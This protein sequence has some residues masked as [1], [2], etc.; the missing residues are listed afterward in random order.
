MIIGMEPPAS[1]PKL[2][3]NKSSDGSKGGREG[4]RPPP[5]S[6]FFQ[7]HA[8]F[9]RIRQNCVFRPPPLGGF[10]PPLGKSWIRHCN[11]LK[12]NIISLRYL[13]GNK[14][15]EFM[16]DIILKFEILIKLALAYGHLDRHTSMNLLNISTLVAVSISNRVKTT[17]LI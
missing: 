11:L 5:V 8:V 4:C 17:W 7:F 14:K 1:P 10:T 12:Y 6:K 16:R 2:N 3:T 15:L 9:G 13:A